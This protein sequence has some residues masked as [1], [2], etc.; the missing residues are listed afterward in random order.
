MSNLPISKTKKFV[1][2]SSLIGLLAIC[3]FAWIFTMSACNN[4]NATQ[5]KAK[6]IASKMTLEEKVGQLFIIR[7]EAL[8]NDFAIAEIE[9]IADEAGIK[10]ATPEIIQNMQKYNLGGFAM[11]AKNIKTPEQTNKMIQD[12][13]NTTKIPL[14]LGIDEEGGR[15]ARIANNPDFAVQNAEGGM[16]AVGE[17]GDANNAYKAAENISSYLEKYNFNLDF[18]PVCD[19]N[20]NP[21]TNSLKDRS[22][23]SDPQL[24]AKMVE[25]YIDGLH[26]HN[27]MST[28]KHFPGDGASVGD[29]H[30]NTVIVNK[31]WEEMQECELIPFKQ[32]IKSDCDFAMIGHVEFPKV[33]GNDYPASLSKEIITDKLKGELGFKGIVL[34]DALAMEAVNSLYTSDKA[35]VTALKAGVDILLMPKDFKLAY[36]GVINAVKS[37]E[38][39][40]DELNEHLI[41]VLNTKIK[42]LGL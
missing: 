17:T 42:H 9:N 11:F 5:D 31:T 39:T 36:S 21:D 27:I 32:A 16:K 19:V 24:V 25:Q 34:T 41:R 33:T 2:W 38:I 29:T 26:K 22:F 4:G 30:T 28:M 35:A 10:E 8:I 7:P 3:V 37:G 20:T 1:S 6:E 15:V 14:F 13:K 23:G 18:A 40:E 12:L